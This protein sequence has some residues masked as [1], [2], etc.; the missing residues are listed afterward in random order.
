MED[1]ESRIKTQGDEE[2]MYFANSHGS[3]ATS[4]TSSFPGEL[5]AAR[6]LAT[7]CVSHN[8]FTIVESRK[9]AGIAASVCV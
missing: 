5:A 9:F 2:R 3:R 1:T 4:Q 6:H 7:P 8:T